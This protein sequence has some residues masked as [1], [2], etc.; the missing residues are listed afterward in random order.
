MKL[1][2]IYFFYYKIFTWT[3]VLAQE[4]GELAPYRVSINFQ[5]G[6]RSFLTGASARNR[7]DLWDK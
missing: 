6:A 3:T 4:C 1:S 5:A 2:K 7:K